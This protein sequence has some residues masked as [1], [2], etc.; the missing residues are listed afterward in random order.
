MNSSTDK[1][2][3]SLPLL[4]PFRQLLSVAQALS[5]ERK[6]K[7]EEIIKLFYP[8]VNDPAPSMS[9][10][11]TA[12]LVILVS[13]F[14]NVALPFPLAYGSMTSSPLLE[15]PETALTT[16]TYPFP[17]ILHPS[18][19]RLVIMDGTKTPFA[20]LI[21]DVIFVAAVFGISF[22]SA[23]DTSTVFDAFKSAIRAP[24]FGNPFAQPIMRIAA[25]ESK[26][27]K[28]TDNHE[29]TVLDSSYNCCVSSLENGTRDTTYSILFSTLEFETSHPLSPSRNHC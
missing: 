18:Q 16:G 3:A 15:I 7:L 10:D 24:Q 11:S 28:L 8:E 2:N 21:E 27:N 29:W 4:H 25:F 19:K 12:Q 20:L 23:I 9:P 6:K 13:E 17:R 22:T 1:L 14:L 5:E 26:D